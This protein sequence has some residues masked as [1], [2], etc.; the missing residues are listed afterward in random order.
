LVVGL[1]MAGAKMAYGSAQ[2]HLWIQF[3]GRR[4][5]NRHWA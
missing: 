3:M 4:H 2:L 1:E 5:K